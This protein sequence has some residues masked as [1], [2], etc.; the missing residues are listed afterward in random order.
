MSNHQEQRGGGGYNR[1]P[2]G[3]SSTRSH[4]PGGRTRYYRGRGNGSRHVTQNPEGSIQDDALKH[5]QGPPALSATPSQPR[6]INRP[7]SRW[8]MRGRRGASKINQRS[9]DSDQRRPV[10]AE[11]SRPDRASGSTVP[12]SNFFNFNSKVEPVI[13]GMPVNSKPP[14]DLTRLQPRIF[15]SMKSDDNTDYVEK[16]KRRVEEELKAAK[17]NKVGY[18]IKLNIPFYR[19]YSTCEDYFYS[20]HHLRLEV[21]VEVHGGL[22]GLIVL[23]IQMTCTVR[24]Q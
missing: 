16:Y 4:R 12:L 24:P 18:C 2:R 14:E 19:K 10:Q 23:L 7:F 8:G 6:Q 17:L 9:C 20:I 13:P 21:E 22:E 1:N 15:K 3:A 5:G 11:E